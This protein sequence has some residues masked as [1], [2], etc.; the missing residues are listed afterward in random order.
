M[1]VARFNLAS[2]ERQKPII[3]RNGGSGVAQAELLGRDAKALA[4]GA[5]E[6]AGLAVTDTFG[7]AL[8]WLVSSGELIDKPIAV[9]NAS[10]RATHAHASLCETLVTMSGRVIEDASITIPVAGTAFDANG[11]L[12]D[13][14]LSTSLRSAIEVLARATREPRAL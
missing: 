5:D 10:A 8:D 7:N 12:S 14:R 2:R 11:S 4:E 6:V 13:A 9:I 3:R 1:T